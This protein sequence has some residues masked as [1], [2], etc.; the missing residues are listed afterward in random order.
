MTAPQQRAGLIQVS[1]SLKSAREHVLAKGGFLV[2]SYDGPRSLTLSHRGDEAKDV[3][4]RVHADQINWVLMR[5]EQQAGA[6]RRIFV[7]YFGP[8][9]NGP[10][11]LVRSRLLAPCRDVSLCFRS[12]LPLSSITAV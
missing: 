8:R 12:L 7:G 3:H 1:P 9:Y 4:R 5:V 2:A 11:P 6:P 10:I